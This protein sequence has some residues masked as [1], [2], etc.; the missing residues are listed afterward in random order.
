MNK[1]PQYIVAGLVAT[2][3]IGSTFAF[4]AGGNNASE[5]T[6][7]ENAANAPLTSSLTIDQVSQL[8]LQAQPGTI[9]EIELKRRDGKTVYKVE[10]KT[11]KGDVKILLDA[12][13]GEILAMKADD[14]KRGG[15]R[16]GKRG[17]HKKRGHH[18]GH[19]CDRDEG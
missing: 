3:L 13:S 1:V 11:D 8:A 6:A 14:E 19:D 18:R 4:A 12:N 9:E 7:S 5:K 15:K 16:D 2:S 10:T 17:H